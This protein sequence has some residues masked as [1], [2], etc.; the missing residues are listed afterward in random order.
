MTID[1]TQ[2]QTYPR[3]I[4]VVVT[5]MS[6]QV[7]TETTY[8][9]AVREP[10]WVPTE[11]RLVTTRMGA[12]IAEQGLLNGEGWFHRLRRDYDLPAIDFN[13]ERI[14]TL[15]DAASEPLDDIQTP[16]DNTAAADA[17]T[18]LLCELTEDDASALHV[19]IAGGRKTMGFYLGYALSLYGRR[20]DR[21]SHVLV[22]P[23][24]ESLP[25]F[26]YPTPT[27]MMVK[28]RSGRLVDVRDAQV[29]LA[30][31]PFVRLR[32]GLP[33]DLLAGKIRF[34]DAVEAA[35]RAIGPVELVIDLSGKRVCAGGRIF[36]LPPVQLAFLAWLARRR[37]K[38]LEW[39]RCP[40]EG[41]PEREY[42]VA[43]MREYNTTVGE[44]G[45]NDRTAE[46]LKAGMDAS[47]FS[48][49]KAKLHKSL[50]RRARQAR[51]SGLPSCPRGCA[52]SRLRFGHR[53]ERHPL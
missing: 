29:G 42:G 4:L 14:L 23:P 45:D 9:L 51:G 20:Q 7:V 33:E 8:A 44:M 16:A 38:G 2:P 40:A 41:V 35:Q 25:E 47:F 46:R 39:L 18:Q 53:P 50:K 22:N 52:T 3:R 24:Y 48:Q 5:G 43:L 1:P 34:H 36:H 37:K 10:A 19:S 28:T 30:E 6:P 27:E 32:E 31:I 11:I 13:A 12:E 49:T 15:S 17:I 21:L 26:F